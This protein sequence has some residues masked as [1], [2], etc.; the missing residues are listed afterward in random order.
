MTK[1]G[2]VQKGISDTYDSA[3]K[4]ILKYKAGNRSSRENNTSSSPLSKEGEIGLGNPPGG[5]GRVLLSAFRWIFE[6]F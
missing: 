5:P 4:R 1:A 2:L 3:R 6:I